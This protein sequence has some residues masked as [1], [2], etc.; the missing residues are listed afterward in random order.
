[1]TP[2]NRLR[3]IREAHGIVQQEI[4]VKGQISGGTLV[5]IERYNLYP[6]EETREKIAETLTIL[7]GHVICMSDIWPKEPGG[8]YGV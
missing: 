5:A 3:E 4:M 1:M 8:Q 7:T 2:K 6:S